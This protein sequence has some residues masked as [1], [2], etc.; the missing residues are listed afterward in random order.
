[1]ASLTTSKHNWN[2][3]LKYKDL[4]MCGYVA[5]VLECRGSVCCAS[6]LSAVTCRSQYIE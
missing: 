3:S 4:I 1:M 5:C 2:V 6:Q